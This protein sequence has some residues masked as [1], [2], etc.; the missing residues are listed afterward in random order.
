M[1]DPF[2]FAAGLTGLVSLVDVIATKGYRYIKAVKDCEDEV[3]ELMVELDVF[4]G[5]L[6]RLARWVKEDDDESQDLDS[7]RLANKKSFFF[8]MDT[9]MCS[10]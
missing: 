1:T 5:V 7:E 3:R 8:L 6:Q 4:G 10:P 9:N 2:S